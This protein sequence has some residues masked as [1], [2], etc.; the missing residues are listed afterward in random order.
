MQPEKLKI[1]LEHWADHNSSHAAG[2]R[3]QAQE[4]GEMGQQDIEAELLLAAEAMDMAG[5][6]L[7]RAI[8]ILGDTQ[9]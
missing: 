3:K 6:H 9:D 7:Q 2:F 8:E 1:K 5:S 4:A